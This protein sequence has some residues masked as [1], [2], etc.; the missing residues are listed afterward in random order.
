MKKLFI[1]EKAKV[2]RAIAEAIGGGFKSQQGYL[3]NEKQGIAITWCSG[4]MLELFEPEDYD[5]SYKKWTLEQLPFCFTPYKK[6]ESR[7]DGKKA[8]LKIIKS[9]LKDAEEVIHAGDPDDEGQLIVDDI[10]RLYKF[11]KPVK[12]I[13]INDNNAKVINRALE[14]IED[15]KKHEA[16]GYQAE[17]RSVADQNVGIN[18]T[19]AYTQ[20]DRA[21]GNNNGVISAGRVQSAIL[22]LV[23][24][25]TVEFK[26]HKESYFYSVSATFEINGLVFSAKYK[27]SDEFINAHSDK[28]DDKKLIIDEDF[29]KKIVAECDK[30]QAIVSMVTTK[31]KS[32]PP[33]LPYNLIKLQQ[34]AS[35][36][37]N[38]DPDEVM[39]ITQSLK[40]SDLI[41]YNRTDSQYLNDDHFQDANNI[42]EILKNNTPTL[43]SGINNADTSLKGRVFDSTKTTAH[44]AI[45]PSE[46]KRDIATLSVKERNIYLLIV[47]SYILQFYP[48]YKYLETQV[49]LSV[50]AHNHAFSTSSRIALDQGWKAF[51]NDD[52]DIKDDTNTVDLRSLETANK[53]TC[54]ACQYVKEKT[55]PKAL[56]TMKV[57]LGDLTSASK[58]IK[59]PKLAQI[60]KERDKDKVGESG[61]IGTASTRDS[62]LKLLF[63]RGFIEK[64][65]KN[66]ISTDQGEALYD[67][68][69][70]IMR[71]P[72]LSAIWVE[73]FKEIHTKDD[74]LE[75]LD[76]VM[77]A[78]VNPAIA[79]IKQNAPKPVALET[80]L[81]PVCKTHKIARKNGKFGW[82]WGCLG[83][84]DTVKPCKNI[85]N[86]VDGTPVAKVAKQDSGFNCVKCDR[87]LALR[88]GSKGGGDFWGCT[89]FFEKKKQCKKTYKDDNGKP[90]IPIEETS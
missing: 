59:N 70:E 11:N 21:A 74:V 30:A 35:G 89:G 51:A 76:Y 28:F 22:G 58:Y 46:T 72:D 78:N 85:M 79:I 16:M 29:A 40:D 88:K 1:A 47:E 63:K 17:A 18:F 3:V 43:L 42:F 14:K 73:K 34:Q 13:F 6:K 19:R 38:Y 84:N 60:L 39:K 52:D 75:F 49:A 8:Q 81:C 55:K 32:T 27:P 62:I 66:I 23:V 64:K 37:F 53:G 33:P 31:Q 82:Y 86:D 65:G 20:A 61:G 25:R 83:F 45:I 56:Y 71:Y 68:L 2:G 90:V 41:T 50:S 69:S 87:P 67:K 77:K 15:N 80:A 26:A 54:K 10:I 12:R 24:R 36:K 9:L 44:H 4:H 48:D 57:L 7:D 5:P